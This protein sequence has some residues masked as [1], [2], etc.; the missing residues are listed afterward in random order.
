MEVAKNYSDPLEPL[1]G[2]AGILVATIVKTAAPQLEVVNHGGTEGLPMLTEYQRRLQILRARPGAPSVV[3]P[4][5]SAHAQRVAMASGRLEDLIVRRGASPLIPIA[6]RGVVP[7][8]DEISEPATV[9]VRS[10]S[11][12]ADPVPTLIGPIRAATRP[13]P[14][15]QPTL[16]EPIR[17]AKRPTAL[18]GDD[19]GK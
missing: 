1:Q 6:K 8:R 16:V 17:P 14:Q 4:F 9:P 19:T 15:A 3:L 7:P 5:V 2:L 13:A 10:A 11:L 18:P 12:T